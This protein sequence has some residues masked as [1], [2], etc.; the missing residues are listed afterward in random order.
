MNTLTYSVPGMSS[1]HCRAAIAAEVGALP[2]V[3]AVEVDLD[4][5]LVAVSGCDLDDAALVAAIDEAGYESVPA[6]RTSL[7]ATRVVPR[8][9]R[10]GLVVLGA[11]ASG[12]ALGLV[13]VL[14]VFAGGPESQITGAALLALGA[15]FMLLAVGSSRF[16]DQPQRWALPPGIGSAGVGLAALLLSPGDRVLGLA[17]WVWPALL[18]ILVGWSL[19]GARRSLHNWSRRTLLYPALA[20]LLLVAAG[21]A[22]ETVAEAT[23]TNPAPGGRTYLVNGHR[24]YLNCVGA[25][26]PTVVLFNGFGERTPSWAW[27]QRMV[28]SS[29]RVCAF[30]RAGQGWSGG[31]PSRQDG[32]ELAS[33][34]H[35]LLR[36]AHIPAPYV[37]AGHSVGGTYALIYAAQYPQQV[38][39]VAL[40]D[41]ATPYQ[42]DLPTYPGFYSMWRRASALLPPLARAGI[43]RFTLGRGFATLPS[44]ARDAARAFAASPRELRADRSEFAELPIAF[45]Q[46]KALKSLDGKPLAVLTAEIGTQNGWLAAQD[47]LALLSTKSVHRTAHGATHAAL[48]EDRRFA[49]VTSRAIAEVVRAAD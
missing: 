27:V 39:G 40:I 10:I 5:K 48:L 16:T 21:G 25:G 35:G 22:Y 17:G 42:F 20:V 14:A 15:G 49:T 30:D 45:D 43:G 24:L 33:D 44:E 11:I 41:S 36:A 13:L 9:G 4:A 37:L 6:A 3:E 19:R 8:T 32:H 29:T 47:Q 26:G 1:G 28:S 7:L 46:A 34:L 23:S 12:L 31:G 2:G 38:A 18:L